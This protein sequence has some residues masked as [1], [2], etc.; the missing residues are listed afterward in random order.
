MLVVKTATWSRFGGPY[1]PSNLIP[2]KTRL[3]PLEKF[4]IKQVDKD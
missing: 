4:E 3:S 2:R 1:L